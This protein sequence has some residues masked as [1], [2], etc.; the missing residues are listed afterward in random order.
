MESSPWRSK[1]RASVEAGM[2]VNVV[3][4]ADQID[5]PSGTRYQSTNALDH[6]PSSSMS[7]QRVVGPWVLVQQAVRQPVEACHLA[8]MRRNAG[9]RGCGA[10]RTPSK[11]GAPV[12]EPVA[13]SATEKLM[14]L[15]FVTTSSSASK[16]TRPG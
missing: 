14:S 11:G 10:G 4:S 1:K 8:S 5:E 12:L 9:V 16:R 15:G 3:G 2:S 6:R 13:S 7:R